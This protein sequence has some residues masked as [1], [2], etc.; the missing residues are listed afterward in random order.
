MNAYITILIKFILKYNQELIT[1]SKFNYE[2][3]FNLDDFE[4]W[5]TDGKKA[6]EGWTID[7]EK[8]FENLG[9]SYGKILAKVLESLLYIEGEFSEEFAA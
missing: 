3:K 4:K 6:P 8:K 1:Y 9:L 5:M 2:K 7:D